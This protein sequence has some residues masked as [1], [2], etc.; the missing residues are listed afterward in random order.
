MGRERVAL[1]L[2]VRAAARARAG[3]AARARRRPARPAGRAG[4]G[5]GRRLCGAL[6]QPAP[7]G[8]A[9]SGGPQPPAPPARAGR[10]PRAQPAGATDGGPG[11]RQV[12]FLFPVLPLFNIGAAAA[13]ARIVCRRA[14]SPAARAAHGACCAAL[15]A[16][17]LLTLLMTA[18]SRHNYPGG[19]RARAPRHVAGARPGAGPERS[20]RA[21]AALLRLHE[22][23]AGA[24][25]E[26]AAAGE[27]LSVHID[28]L[29]AMTG[30]TRFFERGP[31]WVYTKARLAPAAGMR[32]AYTR[33]DGTPSFRL[34]SARDARGAA[35]RSRTWRWRSWWP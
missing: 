17:F 20:G 27:R 24:A 15:A 26:A 3:A 18:A 10:P 29:P 6:L 14:A 23:A 19:A 30:A 32:M 7:Q 34:R 2:D 16:G 31:P 21:G 5:R 4:G 9:A 13:L 22:A 25:A 35:R 33:T 8:G 11:A 28:T 12:R 1:V